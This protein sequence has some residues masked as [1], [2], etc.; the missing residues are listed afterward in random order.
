[1]SSTIAKSA[2][3]LSTILDRLQRKDS[4]WRIKNLVENDARL[5][6]SSG[7]EVSAPNLTS[8]I[9]TALALYEDE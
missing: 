4:T 3:D 1:M 7:I 9:R 8:A 6:N 2:Y 5:I